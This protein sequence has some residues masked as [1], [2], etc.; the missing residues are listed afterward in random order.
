MHNH[1]RARA[2]AVNLAK[3]QELAPAVLPAAES[4]N[5]LCTGELYAAQSDPTGRAQGGR[6]DRRW[7]LEIM[8]YVGLGEMENLP[9]KKKEKGRIKWQSWP[10]KLPPKFR[11]L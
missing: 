7:P 6:I 9:L 8:Q 11:H 5:T 1:T 4:S 2:R 3:H 10:E